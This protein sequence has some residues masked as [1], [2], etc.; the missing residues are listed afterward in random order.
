MDVGPQLRRIPAVDLDAIDSEPALVERIRGEIERTGP[1]TFARF[2]ELALYDPD[3]GYY[4][5]TSARP[6]RTGDF[7]TAPEAHSMFG[8]T[9][10]RHVD[11]VWVALGWPVPFTIREY[12]AGGGA[13]AEGILAGL[14]AEGSALAAAVRY[15]PVEVEPRRL[16]ELRAR[17]A[18]AGLDD[19][20][21]PDDGAEIVGVVVANEVLDALPTHRVV[22]RGGELREIFVGIDGAEFAD[23]ESAPS[24]PALA[25][26][27]STE[28]IELVEGQAAEI[29]LAVDGWVAAAAAGLARGVMLL[30]DY[31]YP[32]IQLY[33]P[34]RRS[35]GT[36]VAYLGQ[37]AHGDLYHAIGRQDLTAHVD[38]TSVERAAAAAGLR[39]LATTTQ[40]RFLAALGAG[41]LLVELQ[42]GPAA[43][44]QAYLE[45]RAALVRMIDPAA[46]GGFQVMAFGR[47]M[48]DDHG[49][50][51]LG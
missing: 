50:P 47:G 3:G 32:A 22:W 38:V 30:I 28:G 7:L 31:G 34:G 10:A 24:T 23:V 27:L 41:D 11:D 33:D 4:R 43:G 26:R 37:R 17:L 20:F 13:L 2:M 44:L 36:V 45:A 19:H 6:G 51:G 18:A 12:G 46:M 40:G 15:R 5:A 16:D 42:S 49:L 48:P 29:C 9:I 14:A 35:S 21:E 25:D 8:R 39:H 1:M